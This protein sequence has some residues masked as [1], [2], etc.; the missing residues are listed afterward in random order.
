MG[1]RFFDV[2]NLA[3]LALLTASAGS[4][5]EFTPYDRALQESSRSFI[6]EG[7]VDADGLKALMDGGEKPVLFDARPKAAFHQERLSGARMPRPAAYYRE[8]E[9]FR[10]QIVRTAPSSRAA[11]EKGTKDLPRDVRIVTYCNRHCGLSK[12]LKL[13]LEAL[14]FTNVKWLDGGIDTWR[15]KG[16]PLEKG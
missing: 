10:Q 13:D 9:L 16:Y 14:G 3:L 2:L 7:A 1:K 6:D 4:A 12:N 11:L 8:Q 15:E 5:E